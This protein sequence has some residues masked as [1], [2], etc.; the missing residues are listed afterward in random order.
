MEKEFMERLFRENYQRIYR[1]CYGK[2]DGS[3][4]EAEDCAMEVFVRGY[5][6]ARELMRHPCPEKWLYVTARHVTQEQYRQR[7][8]ELLRE[9]PADGEGLER[10]TSADG[11]GTGGVSLADGACLGGVSLAGAA[12]GRHG[13]A[14]CGPPGE[15][16]AAEEPVITAEDLCRRLKPKE[17]EL[18]RLVFLEERP[19]GEVAQR[20][21]IRYTNVTTRVHRLRRKL[22]KI[23]RKE[24]PGVGTAYGKQKGGV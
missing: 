3:Q 17:Q 21:G 2:L 15:P 24:Y 18:F 14:A 9:L 6:K 10:M 8:R 22:Q 16:W 4:A 5:E 19:L 1:Y 11:D 20:L 12:S 23:L 13:A 7:M